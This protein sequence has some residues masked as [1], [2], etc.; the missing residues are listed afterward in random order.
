MV[1]GEIISSET[2]LEQM[3]GIQSKERQ[4]RY[5]LLQIIGWKY[6]TWRGTKLLIV[7]L[8]RHYVYDMMHN[9]FQAVQYSI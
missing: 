1:L 3:Y 6:H 2:C 4:W 8:K 5:G 7:F 9:L